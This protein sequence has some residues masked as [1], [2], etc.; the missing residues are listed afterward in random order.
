MHAQQLFEENLPV[1]DRVIAGVCRRGGLKGAD[2]QDFASA[3][4]LAIIEDD[5]AILRD[6]KG[7]S[8]LATYL[9]IIVQRFLADERIRAAGRWHSSAEAKRLGDVAMKLETLLVR[10]Q[11]P[12][13][14]AIALMCAA[15]PSLTAAHLESIAGR[16]PQ[17]APRLRVVD[18]SSIDEEL[19]PAHEPADAAAIESE[20]RRLAIRIGEV[21]R[22]AIGALPLEDRTILRFHF[23][24][25]MSVADIARVLQLPQRP[26]Y[27]RI[28]ALIRQLRRTLDDAGIDGATVV[29][30]IGAP[31][32]DVAFGLDAGKTD[33]ARQT[34][35]EKEAQR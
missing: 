10:E 32:F 26:L 34:N 12:M 35:E 11:R 29:G 1:I 4:R 27:R 24:A 18:A 2:A 33:E 19:L 9:T 8:T 7:H 31:H 13:S 25:Q 21:L 20:E 3:A 14:E 16:L 28:E 5:Y 23:A 15:D 6:W 30:L 17:R 22:D